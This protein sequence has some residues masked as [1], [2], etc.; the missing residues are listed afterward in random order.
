MYYKRRDTETRNKSD[1]VTDRS[2]R[3]EYLGGLKSKKDSYPVFT[4]PVY[5]ETKFDNLV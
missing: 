3:R 1:D 5:R 2:D 4:L